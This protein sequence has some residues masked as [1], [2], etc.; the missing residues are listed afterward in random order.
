M[1]AYPNRVVRGCCHR[2]EDRI[3]ELWMPLLIPPDNFP[4][5]RMENVF[6][7]LHLGRLN[8]TYLGEVFHNLKQTSG[9]IQDG[10]S[11]RMI[12]TLEH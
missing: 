5:L 12:N 11:E 1:G 8:H 2:G 6:A 7:T 3:P 10:M 9:Y 4:F